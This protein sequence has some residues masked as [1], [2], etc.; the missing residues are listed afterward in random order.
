MINSPGGGF[1]LDEHHDG[2][3]SSDREEDD[4]DRMSEAE[5]DDD[6]DDDDDEDEDCYSDDDV[7]SEYSYYQSS[8]DEDQDGDDEGVARAATGAVA[9]FPDAGAKREAKDPLSELDEIL[10]ECNNAFPEAVHHSQ[11]KPPPDVTLTAP[12]ETDVS[13]STLKAGVGYETGS[14]VADANSMIAENMCGAAKRQR[15]LDDLCLPLIK[16]LNTF[17]DG[18]GGMIGMVLLALKMSPGFNRLLL[19]LL[20]NDSLLDWGNRVEVYDAVLDLL[21]AFSSQFYVGILLHDLLEGDGTRGNGTS[22]CW[23]LLENVH[24]KAVLMDRSPFAKKM[25]AVCRK[26]I[27]TYERI[28]EAIKSGRETGIIANP[29]HELTSTDVKGRHPHLHLYEDWTPPTE[30]EDKVAYVQGMKKHCLRHV[31]LVKAARQDAHYRYLSE[32]T[33]ALTSGA[34]KPKRMLRIVTEI[35]GLSTDLPCEWSSGIYIRVDEDRPDILQA[36]IMAP[37]GTPYE[38]G[39]F[40]FDVYLPLSYPDAPPKV[41]F[42][43]TACKSVRFNPNLYNDGKVC[44]SLLGTWEGPGWLPDT[45]TLLQVLLSI[46]SLIF[47]PDP[48][49]YA[50]I[51]VFIIL[52]RVP[53]PLL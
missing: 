12:S 18:Y 9:D 20:L 21:E 50:G 5:S 36:C 2:G 4:G 52:P 39:C 8:E 17:I 43:T 25:K 45:S 35:A 37:E 51:T 27:S 42:C 41:N 14:Y 46:Q 38:N 40:E 24:T 49:E 30:E 29:D 22:N 11:K 53:E 31:A 7:E 47:V 23:A 44:L 48:C 13:T 33:G 28:D 15:E 32:A 26:I 10:D 19:S 6:I 1:P 16:R 34:V 3:G